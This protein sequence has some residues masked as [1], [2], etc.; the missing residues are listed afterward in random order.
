M[1]WLLEDQITI[2]VGTAAVALLLAIIALKTGRGVLLLAVVGVVL[3]GGVLLLIEYLVV[4]DREKIYD[5]I[6]QLAAA[7]EANDLEATSEFIST[8]AT[9]AIPGEVADMMASGSFS[10]VQVSTDRTIKINHHTSP[11]TATATF[12]AWAQVSGF[13]TPTQKVTLTFRL[14]DDRWRLSKF[15]YGPLVKL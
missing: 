9:M 1:T 7:V 2:I 14:E 15:K 13:R 12:T 5:T 6:D 3:L 11:P 8:S 10:K 4:T